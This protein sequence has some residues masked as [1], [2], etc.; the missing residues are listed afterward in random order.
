[1]NAKPSGGYPK[2]GSVIPMDCYRLAQ[3]RPSTTVAFKEIGLGEA[4]RVTR[5]L[6]EFLLAF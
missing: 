4:V 2:I 1:M 6:S 5:E 3:A